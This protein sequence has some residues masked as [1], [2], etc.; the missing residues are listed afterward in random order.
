MSLHHLEKR[1]RERGFLDVREYY[2]LGEVARWLGVAPHAVRF[3]S[4]E[5]ALFL[6]AQ[7]NKSDHRVFSRKQA[8]MLGVI[9]ELLYTELYTIA[10]AK[11]QLRIA[12]ERERNSA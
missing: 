7:R 1:Q 8:L 2:R 4:D 12:A 10:G 11:R 9:R 5:F 3:W 6:P